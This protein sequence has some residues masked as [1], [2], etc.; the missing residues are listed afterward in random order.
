MMADYY[1]LLGVSRPAS[2][3]EIKRAYRQQARELHPDAN[4]GDAATAERFK[5]VARAYEVL[6]RPRP[7]RPL[8]P[9]RRG[10]V[11]AAAAV[12]GVDDMFG[13]GGLNDLFDAF[14]GG[15]PVRRRRPRGGPAGRRG[16]RTSRSSPTSTSSRPCSAPP[17]R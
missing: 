16:A 2:A 7:A 4:P 12:A 11:S 17:S 1:E 13:G 8:R 5:E 15:R 3:E 9:L 10:R 6:S 14:F